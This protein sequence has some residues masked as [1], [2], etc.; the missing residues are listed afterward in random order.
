MDRA[1][2]EKRFG[3]PPGLYILFFTEMWERFS[4]YGMRGLLKGYMIYYL[5]V[6]ARRALYVPEG[7]ESSVVPVVAGD[8]SEVL[9]LDL[10]KKFVTFFDANLD[11]QGQASQI[12]GLYTALVYL[13]PVIG[14]YLADRYFGQRRIV[15]AGGL[16]MA[17]GHFVMASERLFFVA[18]LLL[19]IGNGAFKPNIQTQVGALYKDDDPRR[20]RAYSIFYVGINLG[21]F[22][23]NLICGTLAALKGWHWGF[24]AAGVGMLFG[25]VLY[26][27]GQRFLPKEIRASK[28]LATNE[29]VPHRLEEEAARITNGEDTSQEVGAS[30]QVEAPRK[31]GKLRP[32]EKRAALSLVAISALSIPFWAVYEQQGNTMQ[33]WADE[34]THW[35]VILGFQIPSSWFQSFNPLMIMIFTPVLTM[36]WDAQRRKNREPTNVSKMAIGSALLGASFIIMV[37]GARVIGNGKG[38]MLWP[39]AATLVLTIGEL[40]LS[41][42]GNALVARVAPVKM[43]SMLMGVWL[44]ASFFGNWLSGVIGTLY[45][46]PWV[47][48][49]RFFLL[50]TLMGLL[51]GLAIWAF[52]KP[53]KRSLG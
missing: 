47:G 44:G 41:P 7:A 33:T 13:T 4:Y 12:Y 10:V 42:I 50:L 18:L 28:A 14:G 43:V 15:V 49:E 5:F 30:K 17:L 37:I 35:P 1:A 8:P 20:D 16:L 22:I 45:S 34:Q 29:A 52:N 6:G 23:C 2:F 38:S 24:G 26:L 36:L 11:I 40:Y 3:H 39:F 25:L 46:K 19:I 32:E 51:T 21:S 48:R 53:L 27:W 31:G 9:G